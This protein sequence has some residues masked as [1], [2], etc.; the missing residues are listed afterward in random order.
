[1][2]E[3]SYLCFKPTIFTVGIQELDLLNALKIVNIKTCVRSI[4]IMKT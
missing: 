4:L 1:M 2:F 3:E